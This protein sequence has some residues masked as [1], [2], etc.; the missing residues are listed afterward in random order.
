[1]TRAGAPDR[2]PPSCVRLAHRLADAAGPILRRYFRA[3]MAVAAKADR[4]PVSAADREAETAMRAILEAEV[5]DHG[6]VG[7]EYGAVRA[8]AEFVWVLDPLD[9]T[10]SFVTG[11]PLFATLIGL[12]RRGRPVLGII[13]QPVLDERWVGVAGR[14]TRCNGRPVR[15]RACP[16]LAAAWLYAT[17]PNMFKGGNRTAFDRLRRRVRRDVYGAEC[18]A[19]GLLALGFVDL[20]VE[21]DLAAYDFCALV[22]IVEGAGGTMTDWEGRPLTVGSEGR[23]LAAGDRRIHRLARKALIGNGGAGPRRP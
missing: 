11:K 18:Y 3:P 21:A 7:E 17:S 12:V 20:V 6:I 5:P 4:S 16:T 22:P 8:D 15:T 1:M 14:R 19:Y 13:E 9:G 23:V 2:V 10:Q